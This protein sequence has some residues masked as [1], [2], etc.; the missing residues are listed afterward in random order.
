MNKSKKNAP[1]SGAKSKQRKYPIDSDIQRIAAAALASAE[2]V[3]GKWLPN[4]KRSGAEYIALNPKRSDASRGSFSVNVNTGKWSDFA[5]GDGGHD[6]VSLVKY[7][8]GFGHQSEAAARLA[9]FLHIPLIEGDHPAPAAGSPRPTTPKPEPKPERPITPIPP[10]AM[11]TRPSQ[12]PKWGKPSAEWVYRDADGR[13]L[14]IQRRFDPE[15]ERKQILP[16][17][18]WPDGWKAK[19]PPEPRPLYGLD[20]LAARTDAPVLLCEGEKSADAAGGLLPGMVAVASMNGAQSPDKTDWSPL[21]N[22]RLFIWPDNDDA[23]QKY[24]KAAARLALDAGA[25]SVEILDLRALAINPTTREPCE[26]PKGWDAADAPGRGWN[27][28][29]L[30][31]ALKWKP[32]KLTPATGATTPKPGTRGAAAGL[33]DGF[34]LIQRDDPNGGRAGL[35]FVQQKNRT[36]GGPD[37]GPHQTTERLL[38]S[39]PCRIT[40]A[41]RDANGNDWGIAL[42]FEDADG[43][44]HRVILPLSLLAG[45]GEALRSELLSHGLRISTNSEA[46][47]RFMDF[48]MH[49]KPTARARSTGKAGWQPGGAFVLPDRTIGG[50]TVFFQNEAGAPPFTIKGTL[51]EWQ[52]H[53]S[54]YASGNVLML[55]SLSLAFAAPLLELVN[56]EG[57]IFHLLGRSLDTSTSGKTTLAKLAASVM[58]ACDLLR[59][60][61][62]TDNGL[63]AL[64]EAFNSLLLLLDELGQLAPQHMGDA[65]YMVPNGAGKQRAGRTGQARAVATWLLFC[66]STGE[67][68]PETV[69]NEAGT[70]RKYKAGHAVR[71][72]EIT[73]DAG[74]GMG[75]WANLHG[76]SDP[77]TFAK[78]L[79]DNAAEYHGTA[80]D[81]WLRWVIDRRDEL[82][83]KIREWQAGFVSQALAG[84]TDPAA[85]VRRVCEKFALVAIA[86]ELASEAGITGWQA[87]E[88]KAAAAELFAGWLRQRGGAGNTQER[89]LI[90][91]VR[92]F[93]ALHGESRFTDYNRAKSGDDHQPRTLNRAG[94]VLRFKGGGDDQDQ[95]PTTVADDESGWRI[96]ER[97]EFFV[98]PEVMKAELCAGYDLSDAVKILTEAGILLPGKDRP[99]QKPRLPGFAEPKRVYVLTL[100]NAPKAKA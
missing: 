45:S 94:F 69:M 82:P 32:F 3:L 57:A 11:A 38:L 26:L 39:G 83:A 6:L 62:S 21:R 87:G 31:P 43:E 37:N 49:S 12:H 70:K 73:A 22:R 92:G 99:T 17:T 78:T 75:V 2:S 36:T 81:A 71:F 58:G 60:W 4:G 19:A 14:A 8:E 74:A 93:L 95:K 97:C 98:F 46:R 55:F 56:A 68:N 25:A 52:T 80:L 10:E 79:T 34:E 47:R 9:D 28:D 30:A 20:H 23:G 24:A 65:V 66:L 15:G 90:E 64:C 54:T 61:R 5:T 88:S 16:S 96:A 67:T 85:T 50:E 40:H 7:L 86:G 51:E 91:Q 63:E 1:A 33:P 18:F 13:P 42:E 100:D 59:R 89:A 72:I 76:F 27:A 41:T 35:F 48:L 44:T 53:V 29:N 84:I 77:A